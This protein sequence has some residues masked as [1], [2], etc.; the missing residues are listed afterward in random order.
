MRCLL[1]C[2]ALLVVGAPLAF[3]R[4]ESGDYEVRATRTLKAGA[5]SFH[6]IRLFKGSVLTI[7]AGA[8]IALLPG[9]VIE[10]EGEVQAI[11][12]AEQPIIIEGDPWDRFILTGPHV[13]LLHV[14]FSGISSGV[15]IHSPDQRLEYVT[16]Q[17]LRT[18]PMHLYATTGNV[19]VSRLRFQSLGAATF[20]VHG[21]AR[22]VWLEKVELP[23]ATYFGDGPSSLK[24]EG[25]YGGLHFLGNETADHC[26][27]LLHVTPHIEA[28]AYLSDSCDRSEPGL[29][30]LPGYGTSLNLPQ[31]LKPVPEKPI[32]SGW[33]LVPVLTDSYKL[34]LDQALARHIPATTVYYDWRRPPP[35]IVRDYLLPQLKQFKEQSHKSK[36]FFVAHSFG[37]IVARQYIQSLAYEG[38][39][40]GLIMLG[41]PNEGSVKSYSAWEGASFPADWQVM[42]QLLRYYK[43]RHKDQALSDVQAVRKFFPSAQSIFPTFPFLWIGN[44]PP[45]VE[46]VMQRNTL[47]QGL[48]S[49]LSDLS[50]RLP[51]LM[52]VSGD[53]VQTLTGLGVE[54]PVL[55][56]SVWEDGRPDGHL[57]Q[58]SKGDGTVLTA[59]VI[60]DQVLH[61][62]IAGS[63]NAL[64]DLYSKP[65]LETAYPMHALLNQPL[66]GAA[67]GGFR[68]FVF[69]CPIAVTIKAPSGTVYDTDHPFTT[70]E[71]SVLVDPEAQWFLI[72]D[73]LG[74]YRIT[75]RAL[76]STEVR[77]W[78]GDGG[79][80]TFFLEQG[81]ERVV[82]FGAAQPDSGPLSVDG[83][84]DTT[85]PELPTANRA[86]EPA[87][88]VGSIPR[89]A[90]FLP[91]YVLLEPLL[92]EPAIA[93][94]VPQKT[95]STRSGPRRFLLIP[96]LIAGLWLGARLQRQHR[97]RP[98]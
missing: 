43:Y 58:T 19:T 46:P 44:Q 14:I 7:E 66:R 98:P 11:G 91:R 49:S 95:T 89:Y 76:A 8:R 25:G 59:S 26:S 29:V 97:S 32:L 13:V 86:D 18:V 38:D 68:W 93:A 42:S 10:G 79:I 64:P 71:A 36:V 63:H 16:I 6:S 20:V 61:H 27:L 48:N 45:P 84:Q 12:T 40:A 72:P 23:I 3:V 73:E 2:I 65:F 55:A 94:K 96:L 78:E 30:F 80:E 9:G 62:Q 74:Q 51:F 37:G 60:L 75:I 77:W 88:A 31:L 34:F 83:S 67:R 21:P 22:E 39:V 85:S 15:E 53:G 57:H 82:T 1:I 52:T 69:D 35:E 47:L 70:D 5:Y 17:S 4:S 81:S 41:T 33:S 50:A 54:A 90:V 87:T 28:S 24:V 92:P 56:A